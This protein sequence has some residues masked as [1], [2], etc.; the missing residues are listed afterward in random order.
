MTS[1]GFTLIEILIVIAV[2]GIIT[3][4]AGFQFSAYSK[5]SAIESQIRQMYT[6]MM[7][8]RSRA[9]FEKRNRGVRVTS[10]T[11]SLYSSA[12]DDA[13]RVVIGN[14]FSLTTLKYPVT[15]NN[16]TDIIFDTGGMLDNVSN[17]S[18][19]ITATNSASIDSII[20]S[21]TRIRLGKLKEGTSCVATNINAK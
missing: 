6:D 11:F 4:I 19:C 8:Q 5:K 10:T 16:Y 20:V 12:S 3:T 2:I 7:E 18:I 1:R 9:L 13:T 17:Q 14:P 15:S 21:E